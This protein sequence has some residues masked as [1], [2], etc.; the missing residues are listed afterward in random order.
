MTYMF[1]FYS[2]NKRKTLVL[3]N[4]MAG[5]IHIHESVQNTVIFSF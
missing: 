4:E 5:D 1:T 3:I 2:G